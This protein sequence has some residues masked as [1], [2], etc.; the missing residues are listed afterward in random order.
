MTE[1][2]GTI[3]SEIWGDDSNPSP[4]HLIDNIGIGV[5]QTLQV[6]AGTEV[7]SDGNYSIDAS[8][9]TLIASG[10]REKPV[11]FTA[12]S[13]IRG[14]WVGIVSTSSAT[15]KVQ[16]QECE[17]WYAS[18]GLHL[19]A[20]KGFLKAPRF[21]S[22]SWGLYLEGGSNVEYT[23]AV[24][25]WFE[26]CGVG[27]YFASNV[28]LETGSLIKAARIVRND[29]GIEMTNGLGVVHD[30]GHRLWD[31]IVGALL[32]GTYV[33]IDLMGIWWGSDSGPYQEIENPSGTGDEAIYTATKAYISP[34]TELGMYVPLAED[35][36]K[37]ASRLLGEIQAGTAER[38]ALIDDD[39]IERIV[40]RKERI[41]DSWV[42]DRTLPKKLFMRGSETYESHDIP[43][44]TRFFRTFYWPI[45]SISSLQR[46]SGSTSW[47]SVT[48]NEFSGWY[49]SASMKSSG[50]VKIHPGI[51][52]Y[53]LDSI[54]MTYVH[55]YY[56]APEKIRETIIKMAVI[57]LY[58]RFLQF[59]A[60]DV[61]TQRVEN[62]RKEID[63]E[64]ARVSRDS[65]WWEVM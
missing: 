45:I 15:V 54:R 37:A 39:E 7:I 40:E 4:I 53:R 20:A 51:I 27:M 56:D 42:S 14:G 55:G 13:E 24:D 29:L 43:E 41:Y 17:I 46:R 8:N 31:N 33:G 1:K 34:W 23:E 3:N 10:S 11:K 18:K 61:F 44:E 35:I 59:G 62:L 32:T 48:E 36:R 30:L 26:D 63:E 64:K 47:A 12:N 21:F 6:I 50:Q 57:D 52:S 60:D 9:G 5:D 49:S 2:G 58:Q 19:N 28:P 65:V 16:L 22:C 25:P 38:L